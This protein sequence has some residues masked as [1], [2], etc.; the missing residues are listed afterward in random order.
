VI[1]VPEGELAY[2]TQMPIQSQSQSW[3]EPWELEAGPEDLM[4]IARAADR[5]GYLYIATCDH[6]AVP[7]DRADQ[8]S[9]W[10]TDPMATLGWLAAATERTALLSHVYVLA[11]RSPLMAAKGYA[12]LDWLSGG[13]AIA[14]IGAGHLAEEFEALGVDHAAR[15]RLTD[16]GLTE[17]A[18][19]LEHTYVGDLGAEP[20][21][22]Q[23]P[24]PP[25][26]I[27]GSAPPALRRAA[28]WE[29]WLPQGPATDEA[30]ATIRAER[31]A[32]GRIDEPFAVGHL[33]PAGVHVGTP[34]DEARQPCISGSP[35]QVADGI[36]AVTPE[37]VNAVQ[38]HFR[39]RDASEYAEQV[40]AFGTEVAPLLRR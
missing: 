7:R 8:M 29:G 25:I 2:G 22:V 11:Y 31:E 1:T 12:T 28:R 6:V 3:V 24:R 27:G 35:V 16:D 23:A 32:L 33:L 9:L 17:L 18:H 14:G 34:F 19:A 10:W 39:A 4:A 37:G 21:P 30:I 38:V 15:G 36:L 26:W 13:R 40:E 20:R 5:S